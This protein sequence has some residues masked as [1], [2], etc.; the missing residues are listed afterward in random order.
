MAS[1]FDVLLRFR[2]VN[3]ASAAM[4]KISGDLGALEKKASAFRGTLAL[5]GTASVAAGLGIAYGLK[6][7]TE[8][9]M[10]V[11]DQ[12]HRLRNTLAPGAAGMKDLAA[13][14]QATAATST[15]LGIAQEGLLKQIYLGTSA[16]LSMADSIQAMNVASRVAQGMG[17]DLEATQ[18]TL[19]LA[20]IN[21]K[22][23]SKSAADNIQQLGDVMA[24]A[25]A[26]FDYKNVEELRSQL[27]LAT[28][29]ALS[30][31]MGFKDLVAVLADFTRHGLTGS[32]AG[33]A[34]EESM[35]G[36]LQMQ[37]KLGIPM[38]RNTQGGV[39]LA[40]SLTNVRQ[41]IVHMYGALDKI[42][43]P[44]LKEFQQ[45]FGERG[46][47]ALLIQKDEFNGMRKALDST[48]VA[49]FAQKASQEMLKSPK[50]QFKIFSAGI[51][52]SFIQ[53]GYAILPVMVEL[54]NTMFRGAM[55]VAAFAKHHQELVRIGAIVAMISA[56]VLLVGGAFA[57]AG[58][59][60]MGFVGF[61]GTF[62]K[63]VSF[64]GELGGLTK[65]WTTAQWLLNAAADAFPLFLFLGLAVAAYEV[66]THWTA[67]KTFLGS[68]VGFAEGV[69][70]GILHAL[71]D[72]FV[73][74][75][76]AIKA[77]WGGIRT[78]VF[79]IAGKI[80]RFFQGHSPIPEGPLHTLN[81]GRDIARTLKPQPVLNAVRATA[82][83]VALAVPLMAPS[84]GVGTA[85]A[86]TAGDS[87]TINLTINVGPG[88]GPG[89]HS[90]LPEEIRRELRKAA[91]GEL[92]KLLVAAKKRQARL[93]Y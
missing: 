60:L 33:E 57:L 19:N 81:L 30:A 31:G 49:G 75:P 36:V 10:L 77:A 76:G 51:S 64:V 70:L 3:E 65:V 4:L 84:I 14:Q 88:S 44:I 38:A 27:E 73:Q 39:D 45:T 59:A 48:N 18:R 23:P 87:I 47:R 34:L 85:H 13:A 54:S 22:D 9:A 50:E 17:G 66:I 43:P 32:V 90:N 12:L 40:R 71:V 25:T 16:G 5:A 8:P 83:A 53:I 74:L 78:E 26:K 72:P 89:D 91:E 42:P 1:A 55:A 29:T 15:T 93:G 82:A 86:G 92:P 7:I 46:L 35:H 52:Q 11:E 37:E 28:P 56:G 6:S 67:V 79:N 41:Q 80:S 24:Y 58:S 62:S 61:A 2:A 68:L 21:F 69:G 20:Y 63:L